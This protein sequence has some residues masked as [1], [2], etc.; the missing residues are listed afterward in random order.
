MREGSGAVKRS[1][2]CC[3]VR[4]CTVAADWI[5]ATLGDAVHSFSASSNDLQ[6]IIQVLP[7]NQDLIREL[8][9]SCIDKDF[10][11]APL[12]LASISLIRH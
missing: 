6:A 7:C 1:Y 5:N 2:C 10:D 11:L 4:N 3:A 8:E 9:Q 12:S